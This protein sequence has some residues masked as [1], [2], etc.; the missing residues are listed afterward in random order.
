MSC[1]VSAESNTKGPVFSRQKHK[2][3][4]K[5]NY[6]NKCQ[7]KNE[8][9]LENSQILNLIKR[10]I[11]VFSQ[12]L[13]TVFCSNP[14]SQKYPSRPFIG[15]PTFLQSNNPNFRRFTDKYLKIADLS[16]FSKDCQRFSD[17][18]QRCRKI[19]YQELPNTPTISE[20]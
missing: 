20:E 15:L 1:Y 10:L 16:K 7:H 5:Y 13:S 17:E 8:H 14:G 6:R 18:F 11:F 2:H 3:R 19:N 12:I 4:N 9:S